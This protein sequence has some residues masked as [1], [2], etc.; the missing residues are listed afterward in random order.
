MRI[1][2]VRLRADLSLALAIS[3]AG[4]LSFRS[5]AALGT[6]DDDGAQS[7]TDPAQSPKGVISGSGHMT[8]NGNPV[9]SGATVMSGNTVATG[10]DGNAVIDLGP[11]GRIALKTNTEIVLTLSNGD[12]NVRLNHC[13]MLTQLVPEGVK[14]RVDI[15]HRERMRVSVD[16]GQVEVKH[17]GKEQT[18]TGVSYKTYDE[19]DKLFYEEGKTFDDA[20]HIN[21]IGSAIFK[22]YCCRGPEPNSQADRGSDAAEGDKDRT[23]PATITGKGKLTVDGHE[24]SLDKSQTSI[25]L[26][27]G[28]RIE[29]GSDGDVVI[30]MGGLGRIGVHPSS[31]FRLILSTGFVRADLE[32][33]GWI[34][35]D[36][37]PGVKGRINLQ[38]REQSRIRVT[39]GQSQ[40]KLSSEE[41]ALEGVESK[42]FDRTEKSFYEEGERFEDVAYVSSPG[43]SSTEVKLFCC[44]PEVA[45]FPTKR[46][47]ILGL[48]GLAAAITVGTK[49]GTHTSNTPTQTASTVQP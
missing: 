17:S 4:T 13:G 37:P 33:C 9:Q 31:A 30:D 32:S 39:R 10:P 47:G 2:K 22:V 19:Q 40:V 14:G 23:V 43:D 42:T 18:L 16:R 34:F 25:N 29:T 11:L 8:I 41:R 35:Q 12:A 36:L 5:Q 1:P 44:H 15:A 24:V 20:S 46:V 27:T 26:R 38:N 7:A 48:L 49:V 28:S 6:S 45:H 3:L 21:T